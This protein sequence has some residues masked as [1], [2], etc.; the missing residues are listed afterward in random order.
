[1]GRHQG[2][3]VECRSRRERGIGLPV[4]AQPGSTERVEERGGRRR[5]LGERPGMELERR[6]QALIGDAV[7]QRGGA[8]GH[9]AT[10]RR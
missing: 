10:F 5:S 8:L 9:A 3:L 1:M 6:E 4:R 2:E 7:D